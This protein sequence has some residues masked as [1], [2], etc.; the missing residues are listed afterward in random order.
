MQM[1]DADDFQNDTEGNDETSAAQGVDR[2]YLRLLTNVG[3]VLQRRD[4][5]AEAIFPVDPSED[6]VFLLDARYW[7]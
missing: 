5:P 1:G 7:H 3:V 4:R 2:V 6:P